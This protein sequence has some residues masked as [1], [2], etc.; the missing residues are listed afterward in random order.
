MKHLREFE[1]NEISNLIGDLEDIGIEGLKGF[2]WVGFCP[3]EMS[4]LGFLVIGKNDQDCIDL[5]IESGIFKSPGSPEIGFKG[6]FVDFLENL[7]ENGLIQDAGHYPDLKSKGSKRLVKS[8]ADEYMMNP[9]YCYDQAKEY[10]TNAE[11]VFSEETPVWEIYEP[12]N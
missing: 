12:K 3:P 5:V 11:E 7:F 10:F 8:W 4:H 9:K 6:N 1:D 2:M